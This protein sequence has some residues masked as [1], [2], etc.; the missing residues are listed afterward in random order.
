MGPQLHVL[1][2]LASFTQTLGYVFYQYNRFARYCFSVWP[3]PRLGFSGLGL[4]G[5]RLES[6]PVE[7]CKLRKYGVTSEA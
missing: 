7:K 1:S 6:W 4:K 2:D 3:K 5:D